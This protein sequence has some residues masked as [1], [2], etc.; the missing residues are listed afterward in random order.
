M[1]KKTPPKP[2]PKPAPKPAPKPS[3]KD[4]SQKVQIDES[5]KV[6]NNKGTGDSLKPPKGK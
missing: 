4:R 3:E 5:K 6:G 1:S 2:S